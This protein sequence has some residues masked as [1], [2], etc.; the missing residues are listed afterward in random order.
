MLGQVYVI[1]NELDLVKISISSKPERRIKEIANASGL[2]ITKKYFSKPCRDFAGIEK[3]LHKEFKMFRKKGEWFDIPFDN[4][5]NTLNVHF[6]VQKQDESEWKELILRIIVTKS[7]S[8]MENIFYSN[9][10]IF[11]CAKDRNESK[12]WLIRA[13]EFNKY[14]SLEEVK[15]LVEV[16]GE[17][18]VNNKEYYQNTIMLIKDMIILNYQ[19]ITKFLVK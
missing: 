11:H 9:H 4:A 19:D 10:D 12:E 13:I 15:W 7:K 16:V 14:M 1:E 17:F 8:I 18:E 2:N 3:K 6:P 5:V